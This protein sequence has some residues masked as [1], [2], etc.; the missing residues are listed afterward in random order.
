L[1]EFYVTVTRKIPKPLSKVDARE[2]VQTFSA[3]PVYGVAF[4]D[5][6]AATELEEQHSLSFWDSLI[7]RAAKGVGASTLYS[8]DLQDGIEIEGLKI[9]NPFH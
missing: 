6:V 8:E 3:W 2:I 1:Q 4:E 7:V 5:I 9:A